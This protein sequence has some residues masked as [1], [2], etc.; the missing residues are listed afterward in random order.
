M[1]AILAKYLNEGGDPQ[2][3]L[4]NRSKIE[5]IINLLLELRTDALVIPASDPVH[6]MLSGRSEA[7]SF[8]YPNFPRFAQ[9]YFSN[10]T[11]ALRGFAE[12]GRA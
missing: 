8:G 3:L 2:I 1:L 10:S 5:C 7:D 11:E 12:F 9:P 6:G 4:K